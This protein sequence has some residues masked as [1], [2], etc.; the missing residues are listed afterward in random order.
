MKTSRKDFDY[1]A[2]RCRYWA[3][4]FGMGEWELRVVYED[5]P[6]DLESLAGVWRDGENRVAT[7]RLSKNW[8]DDVVTRRQLDVCAIE[9][10]LHCLLNRLSWMAGMYIKLSQVREEEHIIIHHIQQALSKV[11]GK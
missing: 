2:R 3:T 9:E 1:F 6:P 8:K 10:I 4:R 7:V 11:I 5:A